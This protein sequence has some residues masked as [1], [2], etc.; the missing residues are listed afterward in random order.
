M[1]SSAERK[2]IDDRGECDFVAICAFPA[3]RTQFADQLVSVRCFIGRFL[4]IDWSSKPHI[5]FPSCC[6]T[7]GVGDGEQSVAVQTF[8]LWVHCIL[9]NFAGN[10]GRDR[11]P[12]TVY[13]DQCSTNHVA[14]LF[15]TNSRLLVHLPSLH[16]FDP[17]TYW[18][19]YLLQWYLWAQT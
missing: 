1:T 11:M 2:I 3:N 13:R 8:L 5:G 7:I 18:L 6:P 14:P 4:D 16:F 12:Q 10:M 17:E 15:V 19:S 9:R